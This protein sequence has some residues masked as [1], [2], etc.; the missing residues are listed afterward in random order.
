MPPSAAV[1]PQSW[2]SATPQFAGPLGGFAPHVPS[3]A[4][5]ATVHEPVQQSGPVEHASPACPQNDEAWHVP[6]EQSDEQQSPPEAHALPSVLQL[7]LRDA[8]TFATQLWLQHSPFE[9]HAPRSDVQVGYWQTPP[10]QSPPQQSR[11]VVHPAPSPRQLPVPPP[12]PA[13]T[14]GVSGPPGTVA[15]PASGSA[16]SSL[17]GTPASSVAVASAPCT[18]AS[19]APGEL[20]ELPHPAAPIVRTPSAAT[21]M[22]ATFS[23]RPAAI[24]SIGWAVARA[25]PAR[26]LEGQRHF[27]PGELVGRATGWSVERPSRV[28]G[29]VHLQIEPAAKQTTLLFFAQQI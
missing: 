5:A 11:P 20:P 1:P 29:R 23:R 16:P 21:E 19:R 26:F 14:P 12:V 7:V 2:P 17:P 6:F 13:K 8:Q 24:L 18:P 10:A 28:L 3:V 22:K 15:P 25:G 9:V 27:E 4:P